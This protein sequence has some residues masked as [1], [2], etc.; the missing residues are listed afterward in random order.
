M[1]Q[2]VVIGI[3]SVFVIVL[4]VIAWYIVGEIRHPSVILPKRIGSAD[5]L[6]RY[7]R[8]TA[9]DDLRDEMRQIAQDEAIGIAMWDMNKK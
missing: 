9:G 6:A 7:I 2:L 4:V 1:D 3:I 5:T 8:E